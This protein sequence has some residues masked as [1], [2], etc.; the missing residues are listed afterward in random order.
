MK[1]VVEASGAATRAFCTTSLSTVT[2]TRV[3]VTTVSVVLLAV[4]VGFSKR[5]SIAEE[6]SKAAVAKAA[7]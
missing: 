1:S 5:G 3:I 7:A 6:D 2:A 4:A